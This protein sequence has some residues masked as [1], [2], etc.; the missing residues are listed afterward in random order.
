MKR[1]LNC[2]LLVD[3]DPDDNMFHQIIL[4]EMDV[5]DKIDIVVNGVEAVA[6][7][8]KEGHPPPELIFLDINMPKMNGWEFLDQYKHLN[9][10]QKAR[11]V[12]VILT[13]SA[14]PDDIRK[15]K[16]IQEVTGFETKPLSKE[17]MSEILK[18][19]F[20]DYL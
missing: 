11:V 5:A 9:T 12:I 20:Q 15:A 19:H 13:T 2:I 7:L 4:E 10:E 14:N 18:E 16:Q 8:K 3:D 6:Y 17:M 1:K